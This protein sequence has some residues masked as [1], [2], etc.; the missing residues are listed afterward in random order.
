MTLT[1]DGVTTHPL[2]LYE[3]LIVMLLNEESGYFHQV[4]GWDLNCVVVGAVLAELSLVGRID[5]DMESLIPLDKTEVGDPILDPILK[6]IADEPVQRNTQY[7]IERLAPRAE[8]IIDLTLDRLV[9]LNIL[10]HHDGEFWTLSHTV[11]RR[12]LVSGNGEGTAVEFVTSRIRNVIFNNEIPF[13]RDV[14]IVCLLNTCDVLRFIFQIDDELEKRVEAICRLD[15]IG[16]AIAEAV[17]HNLAGPLLQR[18]ALTKKIPTVSLGKLLFNP[19]IR[20]GNIPALFADLAQEYGPVFQISP[21]FRET[22]IFLAGTE[23]NQWVQRRGRMY[24]RA[25]DY[26]VDFEKVYGSSGV[27]PSLDGADHFRLRKSLSAAYSRKRLAGQMEEFYEYARN[28]MAEW[29]VGE[30]YPATGMS[31]RMINAQISPFMIG[32]ET[33]DIIDDLLEFKE[34]ALSVHIMKMLPKFMLKTPGMKRRMKL[35]E[36]LLER[37]QSVHT[38]AQR[39]GKHRNLVDDYL[40]LHASDPQFMPESNLRFAFTAALVASAYLGDAFSFALY[41]MASQPE[42]YAKIRAEADAL[43]GNGDPEPQDFNPAAI[44]VTHRFLMECL[45]MYPIVPMSMRNVMNSCVVEDYELPVGS[46]I[47]VAQVA[48]HFMEDVFP[49]PFKFDIDRYLPPRNEHL[50][51]GYA[52]YGLGTHMCLGNRWME[53]QLAVN[54]LM[55]AHY[56]TI[57]VSPENFKIKFHP[58]PSLKPS[59]KLK[60]HV[61]EQRRELPA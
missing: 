6:E 32:V 55:V 3:E 54:V 31:R 4:P 43:F 9:D 47:I 20:D 23:T 49:D 26:F 42:I 24:L 25:R 53:L 58:I 16:R 27:L 52:P 18:S 7:W 48:T 61:A 46:K 5:T 15:L 34:R 41:A 13:P 11:G 38:P 45:R 19:H 35:I 39:A 22:M 2:P 17:S 30:S 21:P 44:D 59:K 40:S 10:E 1:I 56:F 37:I 14:V 29:K 33:Q 36:T 60:F 12:D 50:S 8:S 28:H 51:P 57:K